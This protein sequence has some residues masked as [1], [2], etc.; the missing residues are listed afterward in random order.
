MHHAVERAG[1]GHHRG[2]AFV[3]GQVAAQ[4]EVALAC[5]FTHQGIQAR[6]VT[7]AGNHLRSH[8]GTMNRD[9]P[10]DPR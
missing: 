2:D 9:L 6:L 5:Q 8:S 10:A 7:T 4:G 1:L 3:G